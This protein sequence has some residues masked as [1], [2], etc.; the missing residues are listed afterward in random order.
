MYD[1]HVQK[2]GAIA[3]DVDSV[4]VVGENHLELK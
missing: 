4:F 1:L 3:V 2:E